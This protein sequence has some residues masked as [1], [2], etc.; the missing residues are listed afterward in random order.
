[1]ELNGDCIEDL[2]RIRGMDLS[3]KSAMHIN[4]FAMVDGEVKSA[5]DKMIQ[6]NLE[7]YKRCI[8]VIILHQVLK[9]SR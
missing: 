3:L 9:Q 1:M 6:Q 4:K 7:M 5:L 2:K 8:L